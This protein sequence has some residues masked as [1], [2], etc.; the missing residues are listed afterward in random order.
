MRSRVTA[1]NRWSDADSCMG[2][3]YL[4][5]TCIGHAECRVDA[6]RELQT[7]EIYGQT[8]D[9]SLVFTY[10]TETRAIAEVQSPGIGQSAACVYDS[11]VSA[12]AGQRGQAKR[13]GWVRWGQPKTTEV[14]LGGWA[15]GVSVGW[16]CL[17]FGWCVLRGLERRYECSSAAEYWGVG[18]L[19]CIHERSSER[20][21]LMEDLGGGGSGTEDEGDDG[22]GNIIRVHAVNRDAEET[23]SREGSDVQQ[24]VGEQKQ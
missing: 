24:Y 19:C 18:V 5:L 1:Y 14:V 3:S 4:R 21:I 22:K 9:G 13:K 23:R 16:L 20:Q 2:C 8:G 17:G 10:R 12:G 11:R 15:V 7:G 6:D